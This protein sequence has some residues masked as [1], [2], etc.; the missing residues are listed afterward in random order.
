MGALAHYLEAEG[1]ATTQISLIREHTEIIHPPRALW[2][3]F[4]LGRPLGVPADADFQSRVLL[5]ALRLLETPRGPVLSDFP[6][7]ANTPE[8]QSAAESAAWACPVCFAPAP[9]DETNL[10]KLVAGFRREAAQLRVLWYDIGRKNSG[11][12]AVVHFKPDAALEL[13]CA[14]ALNGEAAHRLTDFPL[15]VALRL[16][17]QDLKAFYFEAAAARPGDGPPGSAAFKRWFWTETAAG[18]VLKA[19]KQRCINETDESLR[20][21]GGLLLVPLEQG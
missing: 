3:P 7:E 11:R 20:T 5:A 16:A 15:A 13:L 1:I 2:V 17:A 8:T 10:E 4:E 12:T 9:G 18:L 14:Y 19:I 6:E 21:T